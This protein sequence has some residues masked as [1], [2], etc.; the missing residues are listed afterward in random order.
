MT[1]EVSEIFSG[2]LECQ[3]FKHG[4]RFG[5]MS[6][7]IIRSLIF[8]TLPLQMPRKMVE[9]MVF[10]TSIYINQFTWLITRVN[11]IKLS[12]ECVTGKLIS[13]HKLASLA[14]IT[15]GTQIGVILWLWPAN[16]RVIFYYTQNGPKNFSSTKVLQPSSDFSLLV[17]VNYAPITTRTPVTRWN[18][19][20]PLALCCC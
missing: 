13:F 20:Y 1:A 8:Y 11:I 12:L 5:I 15:I 2:Y 3:L 18:C 7:P 16:I 9:E 4:R 17:K 19:S 10:E 6:V 14:V